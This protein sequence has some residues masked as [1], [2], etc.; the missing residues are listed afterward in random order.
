MLKKL[1]AVVVFVPLLSAC[2]ETTGPNER[3]E[4]TV[5]FA[6][7]ASGGASSLN[8]ARSPA[9]SAAQ[10]VIQG[11]N[12]TLLISDIRLVVSEFELEGRE[13]A[14]ADP[15]SDDDDCADFEALPFL[16]DL[17]LDGSPLTVA[18]ADVPSGTY[19]KLE[20]E[21]EDLD[22]EGEDAAERQAIQ[23]IL[24]T[25]RGSYPQFPEEASM[26]VRGTF[27]PAGGS[28]REF[29][30]YYDA[31][32]EVELELDPPITIPGT[33]VLTV[34]VDPSRWFRSGNQVID[35]SALNGRTVGFEAELDDGFWDV[36]HDD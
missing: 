22:V 21:V 9:G 23:N 18:T 35:L 36:D 10:M 24:N 14:C 7:S 13:G 29:T 25:L 28:A 4:V 19:E 5:R 8:A 3:G 11:A 32:I 1:I 6:T 30:V 12:G 33:Q 17:P 34:Q 16:L 31:E 20:F 2:D 15:L 26:V 27:T